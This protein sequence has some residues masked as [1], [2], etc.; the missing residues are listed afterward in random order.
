MTRPRLLFRP[1][2][3]ILAKL[4]LG[5]LG[6]LLLISLLAMG[7]L[8]MR[9]SLTPDSPILLNKH[10]DLPAFRHQI[11]ARLI[12]TPRKNWDKT[13]QELGQPLN[14]D[15]LLID[16]E[17][18]WAAGSQ[19]E[20]PLAFRD[21]HRHFPRMGPPDPN[22]RPWIFQDE[23]TSHYWASLPIRVDDLAGIPP[24][25]GFLIVRSSDPNGNGL[26]HP[27]PPWPWIIGLCSLTAL[28]IWLPVARHLARPLILMNRAAERMASGR[29][30]IRVPEERSDE[31]GRLGKSL[32]FM[33]E[34]LGNFVHGQK[35]FLGDIAHELCSPVARVQMALGVLEQ[36]CDEKSRSYLK[37]A[38]DE[39]DH[40][41]ELIHELLSFSKAGMA[42]KSVQQEVVAVKDLIERAILREKAPEGWI[43][44][45]V[46][47][48][49]R[50]LAS[51]ELMERALANLIRNAQRYASTSPHLVIRADR[52]HGEIC[53]RVLD[54][55]PGLP[56]EFE[57]RVF[58]P[59]F[60]PNEDR[61]RS[62]GGVGLGLAI[63]RSSV[64]SCGGTVTC[65]NRRPHGLEIIIHLQEAPRYS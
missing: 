64:E 15:I 57:S 40:M 11:E 21:I 44:I 41:T 34:K 30:E 1:H 59:F 65:K 10:G 37:D 63:V 13:L 17:S 14:V 12:E 56:E 51:P 22:L 45:Y 48:Q 26:F 7:G 38:Q 61:N 4:L 6:S 18:Q 31:I 29:F 23:A 8:H 9:V 33:S 50:A 16:E 5:Y 25:H 28:V 36:K 47:P 32:N 49:I 54:E 62:S 43:Q 53:I 27:V 20:F 46:S 24:W 58:D 52:T 19:V 39:M 55:G 2:A 35:R 3:S 42:P 60:R